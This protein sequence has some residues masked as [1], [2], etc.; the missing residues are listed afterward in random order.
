MPFSPWASWAEQLAIRTVYIHRLWRESSSKLPPTKPIR[1][2]HTSIAQN[3]PRCERRDRAESTFRP[4]SP[5]VARSD[6]CRG[7]ST[8]PRLYPPSNLLELDSR[9]PVLSAVQDISQRAWRVCMG[10]R[11]NDATLPYL[12]PETRRLYKNKNTKNTTHPEFYSMVVSGD[13]TRKLSS[14]RNTNNTHGAERRH[15]PRAMVLKQ[16]KPRARK[17]AK[18]R[19][20]HNKTTTPT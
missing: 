15:T 17:V 8:L 20:Q 12:L 2:T 19:I 4:G 9:G 5:I 13:V 16:E 1:K 3:R 10:A 6:L 14:K 11:R 7:V 18:V